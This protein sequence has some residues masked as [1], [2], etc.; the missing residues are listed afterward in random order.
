MLIRHSQK[1]LNFESGP[2]LS[3]KWAVVRL[4]DLTAGAT[5]GPRRTHTN[6]HD[7]R[8]DI[9]HD[10]RHDVRASVR[11]PFEDI[12]WALDPSRNRRKG[13]EILSAP[14]EIFVDFFSR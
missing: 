6:R 4:R 3:P 9:R 5:L 2:H 14:D 7:I 13:F 1:I 10:N 8:R 11:S 12:A